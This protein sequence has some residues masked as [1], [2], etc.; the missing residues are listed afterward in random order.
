MLPGIDGATASLA[1]AGPGW[2]APLHTCGPL[3]PVDGEAGWLPFAAEEP[4]CAEAPAVIAA[5]A[6]LAD[7]A[8]AAGTDVE[9]EAEVDAADAGCTDDPACAAD[10]APPKAAVVPAAAFCACTA[11]DAAIGG[12]VSVAPSLRRLGSCFMNACGLASNSA[13]PTRARTT[14]SRDC[15][16]AKAMSL[17]DWP[18]R[19]VMASGAAGSAAAAV[20]PAPT[21]QTDAAAPRT[22]TASAPRTASDGRD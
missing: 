10:A 2:I 17:R 1:E 6:S 15:V 8:C 3:A 18:G 22:M 5:F 19:T 9:T 13:R 20:S 11:P 12:T 7:E 16:T 14:G 4:A 21:A